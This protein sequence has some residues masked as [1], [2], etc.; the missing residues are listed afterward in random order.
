MSKRNFDMFP[1]ICK[2]L[3]APGNLKKDDLIDMEVTVVV[4]V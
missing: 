3:R 4:T 2:V 1:N